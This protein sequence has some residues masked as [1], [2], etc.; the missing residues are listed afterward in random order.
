MSATGVGM[1]L[2]W[3][4]RFWISANVTPWNSATI[5]ATVRASRPDYWWN[6]RWGSGALGG[7]GITCPGW[8]STFWPV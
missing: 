5:G 4:R 2:V 7:N 6:Y 3:G 8:V 1:L